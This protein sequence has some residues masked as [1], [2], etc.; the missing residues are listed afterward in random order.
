MRRAALGSGERSF[1]VSGCCG[2]CLEQMLGPLLR[3]K[4]WRKSYSALS[5]ES[6]VVCLQ[7]RDDKSKGS[8]LACCSSS[9][10]DQR[11]SCSG[12]SAYQRLFLS[13]LKEKGNR[14]LSSPFAKALASRALLSP[15]V[16]LPDKST[17]ATAGVRRGSKDFG[18]E[19][20]YEYK[21]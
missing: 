7:R 10:R 1:G 4:V 16:P 8:H 15:G 14:R 5:S 20:H 13:S 9:L 6:R 21:Y 3:R 2:Y 18:G 19:V 12:F 17:L 11:C